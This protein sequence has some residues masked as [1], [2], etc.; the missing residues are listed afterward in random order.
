MAKPDWIT[1][2]KNSGT[3][4][5][6]VTVTA[7]KNTTWAARSGSI[8]VMAG[9]NLKTVSITQE[10]LVTSIQGMPSKFLKIIVPYKIF[11]DLNVNSLTFQPQ[12]LL[13][14]SS[15]LVQCELLRIDKNAT[16][17]QAS[18]GLLDL[19]SGK[20]SLADEDYVKGIQVFVYKGD[21]LIG[22]PCTITWV[23][24]GESPDLT[25]GYY[26]DKPSAQTTQASFGSNNLV[27]SI[28]LEFLTNNLL[29]SGETQIV[30]KG[31]SNYPEIAIT[32][33]G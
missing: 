20:T 13:D 1:L 21:K 15:I 29:V 5:D 7:A 31:G 19:Y 16:V 17:N 26:N 23:P 18:Y 27:P 4:N 25:F 32:H 2:S 3:G 11:T 8:T 14:R 6:T 30:Y 28:R 22:T 12:I 33:L 24:S 9:G 10:Q